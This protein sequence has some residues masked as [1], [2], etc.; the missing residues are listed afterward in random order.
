MLR[1]QPSEAP[2]IVLAGTGNRAAAMLLDLVFLAFATASLPPDTPYFAA[3][4]V[5]AALLYFW[6]MPLSP[7]QGTLGKWICRIKLCD[8][9]GRRLTARASAIRTVSMLCWLGL[10]PLLRH[11]MPAYGWQG[12]L[13]AVY[14]LAVF[15][16]WASVNFLSRRESL[17][18]L[19]AGSLV[20]RSRADT[21]AISNAPLM[22]KPGWRNVSGMLIVCLL[23][24][25]TISVA[26]GAFRD[27]D[28]RG[29]VAYAIG[30]TMPL[31]EKVLAFHSRDK[32]WP[33]HAELGL[34][35]SI[36][37]PAGGDY[38]LLPGGS[39]RISFSANPDLKGRSLTFSHEHGRWSR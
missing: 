35:E 2:A 9:N 22:Q 30:E 10:G 13:E 25:A 29:R 37:Y 12:S 36:P 32:R 4:K 24:G 1:Y 14:W 5:L 18:D 34:P 16:P 21:N 7:L 15:L 11:T 27:Q 38:R 28:R 6:L 19:L 8:R 20:V 23:F 3:I 31:R 26:T 17:F 39:I 33:T